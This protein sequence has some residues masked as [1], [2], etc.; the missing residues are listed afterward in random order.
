MSSYGRKICFAFILLVCTLYIAG[1]SSDNQKG[2][3]KSAN[4]ALPNKVNTTE[5]IS[6]KAN[7]KKAELEWVD[8]KGNHIWK[9][10]LKEGKALQ[11][12]NDTIVE[13]VDVKSSLFHDGRISATMDAPKVTADSRNR[14]L[15]ASGGV[16]ITSS[17]GNGYFTAE[18]VVWKSKE[19]K[20]YGY[21]DVRM[22][23]GS[24]SASA[25]EVVA[26]TALNKASLKNAEI[27]M[28]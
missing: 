27:S 13:I 1:C 21:G 8:E 24:I 28:K 22:Q 14:M 20:V 6:L 16:K 25:S 2:T 4:Q 18:K 17:Q 9:A 26:D 23:K 11:S 3:G 15:T 7:L 12:G 5:D 19:N 10:G